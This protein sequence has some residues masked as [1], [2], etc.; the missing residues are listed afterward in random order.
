MFEYEPVTGASVYKIQLTDDTTD[1]NFNHPM[2]DLQDSATATLVSN[3]VFGRKYLWRYAGIVTGRQQEWRGPFNFEIDMDSFVNRKIVDLVVDLNDTTANARGLI[4]NDATHTIVDRTGKLVW[5]LP[6]VNWF[7]KLTQWSKS[8]NGIST[9]TKSVAITP[10]VSDLRLT[11]FGTVTY[12]TDSSASEHTLDGQL[13]WKAPNDGKVSGMGGESYNHDF[14]RLPNGNYAVLGNKLWRKLPPYTDTLAVKKKYFE[15]STFLGQEYAKVEFGTVIEYDKQ[16]NI[17]WSWCSDSY[18]DNDPMQPVIGNSET[19]YELKAHVNAFSIDRKNEF[20]YLGFRDVSRIV[21]VEKSTGKVVDS[22]GLKLPSGWA[23]HAVNMHMQHDANILDD[24]NLAIFNN[25]DYPGRDSTPVVIVISP[26]DSGKI[27]WQFDCSFDS[28]NKRATRNGGNVDQLNNGNFLVCLG[29]VDRIIEV[30]R[31]KKIVWQGSVHTK[32]FQGATYSHR[33]YRAHYVSSLYP[34]YFT[35]QIYEDTLRSKAPAINIRIFNKGSESDS[36][37]VKVT[38]KS[39]KFNQQFDS[40]ILSP[41][42]SVTC[43][44]KRDKHMKKYDFLFVN[45]TSKTNPDFVRKVTVEIK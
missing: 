18:F 43:A 40:G 44:I 17:V 13:L 33:L 6:G 3:L 34:C 39:G 1:I 2:L 22:W 14:K 45:V 24:G 30:T 26:K 10:A 7:Y 32:E 28:L 11:P 21:K 16:G 5:Y 25:N 9:T 12:L 29:N 27:I 15:R 20:A 8:I 19:D 37:E 23:Q 41:N 36:Y 42:H 38:S 31:D 35:M 4:I